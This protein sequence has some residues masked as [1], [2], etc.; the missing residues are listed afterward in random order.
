MTAGFIDMAAITDRALVDGID[1]VIFSFFHRRMLITGLGEDSCHGRQ[2]NFYLDV[3]GQHL[4]GKITGACQ[5][6]EVS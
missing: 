6:S 3:Q 2:A 5:C 1:E 4:K